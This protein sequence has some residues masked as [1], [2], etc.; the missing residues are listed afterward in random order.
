[1]V[2]WIVAAWIGFK[3]YNG[4]WVGYPMLDK[5]GRDAITG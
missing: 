4:E 2:P 5:Y 1:V 3:A